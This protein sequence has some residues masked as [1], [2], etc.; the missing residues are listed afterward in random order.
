MHLITS[1]RPICYW[2]YEGPR[3]SA[4]LSTL[5]FLPL[6]LSPL[7]PSK[8]VMN[9][10]TSCHAVC[11]HHLQRRLQQVLLIG[12]KEIILDKKKK[13]HQ[14]SLKTIQQ[15]S[16]T[17]AKKHVYNYK[18]LVTF[19]LQNM[20]AIFFFSFKS[21]RAFTAHSPESRHQ[22]PIGVFLHR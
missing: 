13:S 14:P 4:I 16:D 22:C 19:R 21:L 11:H 20:S 18:L 5:P 15:H 6:I 12:S 1:C 17:T 3:N 2:H 7:F 10:I 9:L 8:P